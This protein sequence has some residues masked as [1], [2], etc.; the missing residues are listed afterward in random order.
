MKWAKEQSLRN[1]S[2]DPKIK[3][4]DA[5]YPNRAPSFTE[6]ET[7]AQ[8]RWDSVLHFLVGSDSTAYEDPPDAVI[9]F[10]Q[11]TGLMQE[12]P[13]WNFKKG[14][15]APLVITS[16][17][18]EFM[19][20]EVH[21]QVWQFLLQYIIKI[22]QT[23]VELQKEALLFL[24]SLSYCTVGNAYPAD[25]LNKCSKIFI[26][27]YSLFGLVHVV[28]IGGH[29]LFYPTRVA[30]NLVVGGLVDANIQTKTSTSSAAATR[31]LELALAAPKPSTHHIAIIV[32]TNFQVC[33][34]TTSSLHVS[35]LG[36]FCDVHSFRRLPNVIFYRITRDSIKAAFA[37]GIQASQILKFLKL[38]AH[39]RLRTG[40]QSLLPD[41][42]EDQ[43][44]LWDRERTRVTMTQVYGLQCLTREEYRAVKLYAE[45][46][47][48]WGWFHEGQNRILIKYESAE[49]VMNYV[50]QWRAQMAQR[51]ADA[52]AGTFH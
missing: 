23:K 6:L 14:G 42:V 52:D 25:Q 41:N 11:E 46:W 18:Y 50:R 7:F 38:N 29:K 40:D 3:S 35:M 27:D 21:V 51:Q 12:D 44:L 39:P 20:L 31:A 5:K 4:A 45:D 43:I 19:L 16:K 48:A 22:T 37:L 17:G 15:V 8:R 36:L 28:K 47:D 24:I 2:N 34:Y 32:Q 49:R 1:K 10:L 13:E 33:A 30:V 26:Q 9:Q